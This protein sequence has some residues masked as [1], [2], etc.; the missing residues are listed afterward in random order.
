[1]GPLLGE[2][3]LTSA[4]SEMP[5]ARIAAAKDARPSG[6]GMLAR[7]DRGRAALRASSRPKTEGT[8][9]SR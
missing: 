3:R 8:M 2:A 9:R 7:T 1:M 6:A 5:G 4:I